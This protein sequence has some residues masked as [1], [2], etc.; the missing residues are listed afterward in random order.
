LGAGRPSS[1]I[2]QDS[3]PRDRL[4]G[5]LDRTDRVLDEA[6][7]LVADSES[8]RART[9]LEGAARLQ[10]SARAF[11]AECR[12]DN[13]T[14]CEGAARATT[15]AR[16]SALH[17]IQIAREQS[18]LEQQ[19]ART[20]ER[21]GHLLDESLAI[22]GDLNPRTEHLLEQGRAQLD[23]AREQYQAQQFAVAL[24]LAQAAERLVRE[25]LKLGSRGEMSPD[26]VHRELERTDRLIERASPVIQEGEIE[27]AVHL[28]EQAIG[29][30]AR[31]HAHLEE[32][33]LIAAL[34][35]TRQ[36]REQVHRALRLVEGPVDG[37]AVERAI[38]QTDQLIERVEPVVRASGNEEGLRLLEAGI[39]HQRRAKELLG[40]GR[41]NLALAQ[42]RVARNLVLEASQRASNERSTSP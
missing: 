18:T 39:K 31:A 30:Q 28:L 3:D 17:A 23:R 37:A 5:E 20:I 10:E 26:R 8:E 15:R 14:A 34:R 38:Q 41:L 21:V 42:T 36:A 6:R 16:R 32:R 13:R 2:A 27:R 19:A 25:A 35:L 40:E 11:F 33:R 24:E 22:D 4:A 12:F 7:E 9:I 29:L 1:A